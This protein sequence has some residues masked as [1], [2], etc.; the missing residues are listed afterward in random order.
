MR[1]RRAGAVAKGL[2]APLLARNDVV[3]ATHEDSDDS[4]RP[5]QPSHSHEPSG[6]REELRLLLATQSGGTARRYL[7]PPL[8]DEGA[9]GEFAALR[10]RQDRHARRP[11]G[12]GRLAEGT[13]DRARDPVS[14]GARADA[15]LHG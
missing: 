13:E 5:G 6:R 12:D 8:L 10:G 3:A 1:L 11:P 7:A 9:V 14:A 15:G 2:S 4:D